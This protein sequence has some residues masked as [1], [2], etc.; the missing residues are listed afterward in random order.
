MK[1]KEILELVATVNN[2][3]ISVEKYF[4]NREDIFYCL[5]SYHFEHKDNE[6]YILIIYFKKAGDNDP[7][8]MNDV[9]LKLIN[10]EDFSIEFVSGS[11]DQND[12][13]IVIRQFKDHLTELN[14]YIKNK[15]S[16]KRAFINKFSAVNAVT[17]SFDTLYDGG[18]FLLN[19]HLSNLDSKLENDIKNNATRK[20]ESNDSTLNMTKDIL[21]NI[22]LPGG[23]L[24]IQNIEL[25][26]AF[27]I[28]YT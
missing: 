19:N 17:T 18:I 21:K 16:L 7:W 8:I 10:D 4:K 9:K 1:T 24:T 22:S 28:S 5:Y 20:N 2:A 12:S 23:S 14:S 11:E 27:R 15:T 6:T 25:N 13:N 3:V 26:N